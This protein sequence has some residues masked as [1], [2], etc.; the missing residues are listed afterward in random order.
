MGRGRELGAC[1][2]LGP[3]RG[4]GR[5]AGR[6][7]RSALSRASRSADALGGAAVPVRGVP[8]AVPDPLLPAEAPAHPQQ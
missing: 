5:G 4:G 8:G 2:V 3:G 6:G 7:P 1:S